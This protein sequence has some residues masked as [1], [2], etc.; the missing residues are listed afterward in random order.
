MHIVTRTMSVE[1]PTCQTPDTPRRKRPLTD[2]PSTARVL[3][4]ARR[5][6]IFK[7]PTNIMRRDEDFD[8]GVQT[9]SQEAH[10]LKLEMNE[11]ARRL[12]PA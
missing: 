1:P 12:S 7:Q 2:S 10:Y 8:S 5:G 4:E 3:Q 11:R 9:A 6:T